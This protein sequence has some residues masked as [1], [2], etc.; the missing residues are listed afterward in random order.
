M[1]EKEKMLQG[2]L[3][4]FD[5]DLIQE[6]LEAQQ[7]LHEYNILSPLNIAKKAELLK[8][9]FGNIGNGCIV[10]PNF[11]CDFGF[12]ILLGDNVFLNANVVIL[13]CAKVTIGN[14]VF[15]AP[16]VG[17]YTSAHP[18]NPEQR[19]QKFEYAIP[20]AIGNN[21]WIGGGVSILPGVSIGDNS[22]IGA[23]SVVNK[24]IPANVIAV[25]NPCKV[26][27]KL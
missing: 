3:F 11:Y 18:F 16:N 8:R 17:V 27:K 13:D 2:Q 15:I 24:D 12:N 21:V 22:V 25:G 7:L 9:I 10:K 23:G 4:Q 6:H 5:A 20:I 26:L 14:D 1:T 19:R